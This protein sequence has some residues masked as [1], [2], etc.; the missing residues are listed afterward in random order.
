MNGQMIG[1]KRVSSVGQNTIRQLDGLTL[2]EVFEDKISGKD[3]HRPALQALMKH[4]RKGDTVIVHSMDR[5]ARN[6]DDLRKLVKELT[7]KAV[8]VQF[9]KENLIF[10]GE[11]SPMSNLLLNLLGAVAEFER[12]IIKDRQ[13]EGVQ[14]AKALGKY[15][16]RPKTMTSERADEIKRRVVSGEKKSF[17][18]RSMGIS[19]ETVYQYLRA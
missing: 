1:Y 15:K 16:G 10:T 3:T 18:A 11:D 9:V 12:E 4:A 6:I 2:D 5:L 7:G 19:R 17:I 13:R 8:K 14:I